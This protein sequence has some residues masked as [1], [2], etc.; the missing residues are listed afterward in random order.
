MS[1]PD[2]KDNK[3]FGYD[4]FYSKFFLSLHCQIKQIVLRNKQL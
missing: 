2:C 4:L 3:K 1:I